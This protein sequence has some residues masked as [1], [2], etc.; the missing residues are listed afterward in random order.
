MYNHHQE[1]FGKFHRHILVHEDG[2]NRLAVAPDRGSCLLELTLAGQSVI[3]ELRTPDELDFDRWY[4]GMPLFPFPNRLRDGAYRWNGQ[5]FQFPIN[6]PTTGNALHGLSA[7]TQAVV[8]RIDLTDQFGM[9][10]C[11]YQSNGKN[12]AYPF[13]YTVEMSLRLHGEGALTVETLF[14]NDSEEPIPAGFGWHPYFTLGR[15]IDELTLQMPTCRLIGIDDRMLPT[16]KTYDYDDFAAPQPIGSTI[17]DNCFAL[18]AA[19]SGRAEVMLQSAD[20]TIRYWQETGPGKYNYLQL[21]THPDRHCIAIEPMT[22]NIDAF[23]NGNGLLT[24]APGEEAVASFG[25]KME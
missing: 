23:N 1:P 5:E 7:E 2:H 14:R 11:R 18:E 19:S 4:R 22:C 8:E 6:D 12:A 20:H 9:I 24:L 10:T 3:D 16:G 21:F 25:I 17:L 15:K 13:L